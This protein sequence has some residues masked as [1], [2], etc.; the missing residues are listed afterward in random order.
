ML[1]ALDATAFDSRGQLRELVT[2]SQFSGDCSC[3]GKV[4]M[5]QSPRSIQARAS[6][7]SARL[8]IGPIHCGKPMGD[9]SLEQGCSTAMVPRLLAWAAQLSFAARHGADTKTPCG[10]RRMLS[11]SS[12]RT[13]TSGPAAQL[14][15]TKTVKAR[16]VARR[17]AVTAAPAS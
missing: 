4:A 3:C 2:C 10:Q 14:E 16:S 5:V 11:P 6:S 17:Q 15:Q 7:V 12:L 1:F 9:R 8:F 13:E